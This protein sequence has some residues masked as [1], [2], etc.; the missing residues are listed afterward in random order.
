MSI[1]IR[2]LPSE[3]TLIVQFHRPRH[4]IYREIPYRY[5]DS[6]GENIKTPTEV[7]SVN[8]GGG[9]KLKTKITRKGNVIHIRIGDPDSFVSGLRKYE[10]FYKV[11]NAVLFFDK[12]YE[13]YW[14]VTGNYWQAKLNR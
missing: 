5:T 13:L 3:N 11:E 6:Q 9:G 10:I 8:D 12:H 4:G 14:N 1:R 7:L 2:L